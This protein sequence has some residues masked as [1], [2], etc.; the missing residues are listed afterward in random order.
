MGF[1]SSYRRRADAL[2]R[3]GIVAWLTVE[4]V[5]RINAIREAGGKEEAG[6]E[7]LASMIMRMTTAEWADLKACT[8]TGRL[9]VSRAAWIELYGGSDLLAREGFEVVACVNCDDVACKGWR[10]RRPGSEV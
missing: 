3:K 9:L 5:E 4:R 8:E 7:L 6:R 1:S 10:V 2:R